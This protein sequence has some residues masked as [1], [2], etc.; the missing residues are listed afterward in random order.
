MQ[1]NDCEEENEDEE[2]I[3]QEVRQRDEDD[4][5]EQWRDD[6]SI[7]FDEELDNLICDY[8]NKERHYMNSLGHIKQALESKAR[9][10]EQYSKEFLEAKKNREERQKNEMR[11][12]KL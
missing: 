6:C 3:E 10:L 5:Y 11:G 12:N 4:A 2:A 7:G 8:L 9:Y 1:V